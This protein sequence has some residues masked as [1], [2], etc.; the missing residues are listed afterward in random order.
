VNTTD[1]VDLIIGAGLKTNIAGTR[2]YRDV[3]GTTHVESA[4]EATFSSEG[5]S[6]NEENTSGK[7]G[8]YIHGGASNGIG[9]ESL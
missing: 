8:T 1:D 5:G 7:E 4:I 2:G 3:G 9:Y 6:G